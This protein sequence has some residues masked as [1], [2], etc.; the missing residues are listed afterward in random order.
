MRLQRRALW[1]GLLG[2]TVGTVFQVTG[3]CSQSIGQ[4]ALMTIDPCAV[5]DCTGGVLNGA[6]NPCGVA[7]DPSDD[8]FV[9]C[10]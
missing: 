6:F 1:M 10:P 7:G 4:A 8:I 3:A 5:L 2:L 9:K